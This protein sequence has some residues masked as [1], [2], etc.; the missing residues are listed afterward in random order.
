MLQNSKGSKIIFED[1][2]SWIV[3]ERK[4][5]MWSGSKCNKLKEDNKII[6]KVEDDKV[7]VVESNAD[8]PV[9]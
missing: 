2:K 1:G 5:S 8:K 6:D 9:I 4:I 3:G 7:I